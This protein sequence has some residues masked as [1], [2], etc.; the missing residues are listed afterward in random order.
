MLVA[1]KQVRAHVIED[2]YAMTIG[3]TQL[4][5]ESDLI[6][7]RYK[8][9]A[10][11]AL[12]LFLGTSHLFHNDLM[13]L[14]VI[15]LM[16]KDPKFEI[17]FKLVEMMLNGDTE[18]FLRESITINTLFQD[19]KISSEKALEKVRLMSILL[20]C[21]KAPAR[22]VT[23]TDIA[24]VAGIPFHMVEPW[25]VRAV[26]MKLLTARLDQVKELI[27]VYESTYQ[28]FTSTKWIELRHMIKAI[29]KT[30]EN[31]ID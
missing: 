16:A 24:R 27:H 1:T 22:K 20:F 14:K 4:E 25:V 15:K 11:R 19:L 17:N 5:T 7:L 10:V 9:H 26:S 3:L 31:T 30:I 8:G 21:A 6:C 29:Q 13:D 2:F 12:N 28:T 18:G 23:Y